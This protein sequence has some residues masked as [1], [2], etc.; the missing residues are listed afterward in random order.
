MPT[1]TNMTLG[2]GDPISNP[3][4]LRIVFIINAGANIATYVLQIADS[5]KF[6]CFIH[7]I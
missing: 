1:D 2:P 3:W 7:K 4:W 5:H 6:Y